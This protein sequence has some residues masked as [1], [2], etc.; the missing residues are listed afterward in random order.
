MINKKNIKNLLLDGIDD[1][2]ILFED[3]SSLYN[4]D[5]EFFNEY[6]FFSDEA[7]SFINNNFNK[8]QSNNDILIGLTD[9]EIYG[10]RIFVGFEKG[11][12]KTYL[13]TREKDYLEFI[14]NGNFFIL[15]MIVNIN[16][17][18]AD[19]KIIVLK[20]KDY[21]ELVGDFVK[22]DDIKNDKVNFKNS[23]K[24]ITNDIVGEIQC[25][26]TKIIGIYKSNYSFIFVFNQK[27]N[28]TSDEILNIFK[29]KKNSNIVV[30][31]VEDKENILGKIICDGCYSKHVR[32]AFKFYLKENY[33][34]YKYINIKLI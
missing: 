13:A 3:K 21:E 8:K 11:D 23:L 10:N 19:D 1:Y 5:T 29:N 27:T 28:Y 16:I 6:R 31:F 17:I 7:I 4:I 30:D 32:Q 14:R 12:Y 26:D 33:N 18:T 34:N 9:F 24:R 25:F 15:P 2:I 22:F 20:T